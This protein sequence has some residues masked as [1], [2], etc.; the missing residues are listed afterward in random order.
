MKIMD[1]FGQYASG[2]QSNWI[3]RKFCLPVSITKEVLAKA[4][5]IKQ[6]QM[7]EVKAESGEEDA[8][9]EEGIDIE[10]KPEITFDDFMKNCS[11]RWARLLPVR[12]CRNRKKL[13]YAA[14]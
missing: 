9:E 10:A 2:T 4:E 6:K 1:T 8:G 3:L 7:A 5:E 11:S 14:R 12:K 13:T